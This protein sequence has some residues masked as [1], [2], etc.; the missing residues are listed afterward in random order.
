MNSRVSAYEDRWSFWVDGAG[1]KFFSSTYR[2]DGGTMLC[3]HFPSIGPVTFS[4]R[5]I[6][7]T[8]V[9][10]FVKPWKRAFWR[11]KGHG[12]MAGFGWGSVGIGRGSV[13]VRLRCSPPD[14]CPKTPILGQM[15]VRIGFRTLK[16]GGEG[17][18]P[19]TLG[20]RWGRLG[21][22]LGSQLIPT[23]IQPTP[24]DA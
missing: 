8:S 17:A 21:G 4:R 11:G 13:E 6:G 5:E 10:R 23:D 2:A 3:R 9:C 14:W 7:G 20:A 1:P 19:P 15:N 24:T 18:T 22:Q 16:I 12:V